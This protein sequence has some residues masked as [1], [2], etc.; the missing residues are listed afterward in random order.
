MK[1]TLKSYSDECAILRNKI[2]QNGKEWN[3]ALWQPLGIK[4]VEITEDENIVI[5]SE[6]LKKTNSFLD[7]QAPNDRYVVRGIMPS[8]ENKTLTFLPRKNTSNK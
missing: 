8:P 5:M 2:E 4:S 1:E 7:Y 3:P 6:K